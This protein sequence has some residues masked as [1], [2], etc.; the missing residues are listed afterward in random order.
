[1]MKINK[2]YPCRAD[3]YSNRKGK[4]EYI[5]I[6]YVGATGGALDN[7]KY[8]NSSY[9]GNSAHFFVGHASEAAAVYQSVDPKYRAWHCGSES[10]VYK[11]SKCRNDNSIGIE[12]CCHY[13]AMCGWYFDP[14]SVDKAIELTKYLMKVYD[15]PAENVLRHYDVTGKTCPAPFVTDEKQ[16]QAF[17]SKLSEPVKKI[18]S[19]NDIVWELM[20]G[21]HKIK[22]TEVSKAVKALDKAKTDPNYLSL[23]WILYKLV[24]GN[25]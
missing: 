12:I 7:A 4:I 8:Y 9:V 11:H 5:V 20:N 22:I 13:D 19:G 24:N 14:E 17:L 1:M 3:N 16:W 2:D 6:H 18:E 21:P 10:G 23:Y 25:E 15:V